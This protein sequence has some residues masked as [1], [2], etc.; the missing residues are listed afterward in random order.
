MQPA[1][2]RV[3]HSGNIQMHNVFPIVDLYR[4][5][6]SIE[7]PFIVFLRDTLYTVSELLYTVKKCIFFVTLY[8]EIYR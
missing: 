5:K 6:E 4:A 1:L 3:C 7:T 8:V 2:N